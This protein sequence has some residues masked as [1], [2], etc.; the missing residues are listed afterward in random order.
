MDAWSPK[1][2]IVWILLPMNGLLLYYLFQCVG[3]GDSPIPIF[4][5]MAAINSCAVMGWRNVSPPVMPSPF[6][7]LLAM[8]GATT[9]ELENFQPDEYFRMRRRR[10]WRDVV[11][12]V[13]E[14]IAPPD[15]EIIPVQNLEGIEESG[16]YWYPPV[17]FLYKDA[18]FHGIIARPDKVW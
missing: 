10:G 12:F 1:T 5:A 2:L 9:K 4:I 6:V 18:L 11:I 14:D 8:R 17:L 3:R 13:D 7:R 15:A 16:H